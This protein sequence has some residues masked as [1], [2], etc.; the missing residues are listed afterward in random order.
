MKKTILSAFVLGCISLSAQQTALKE[1]QTTVE[2]EEEAKIYTQ[3]QIRSASG[4]E[5]I[6][7]TEDFANGIP[8]NWENY[9]N[10][11][12]GVSLPNGFWEYRGPNTIPDNTTGSRGGSAGAGTPLQSITA[13]NG[14]VIFDSD[15][16]DDGGV[17]GSGNGQA[18]A[19]HVGILIT[20]TIDLSGHPFVELKFNA[21]VR[22]LDSDFLMAVSTDGGLTYTDTVNLYPTL[23]AN[24]T[25]ARNAQLSVN[26]SA[27]AGNQSMVRIAFIFDGPNRGSYYWMMDDLEIRDLP[28]KEMRFVASGGAPAHDIIYDMNGAPHP[29]EGHIPLQQI[30]PLTF[31]SNI[32]NYGSQTQTNVVLEV[33]IYDTTNTL[34]T[35]LAST[36]PVPAMASGD[37]VDF[38]TFFTPAWTPNAAGDY[39][40]VYTLS[41]DTISTDA[42][43]DSFNLFVT[44]EPMNGYSAGESIG[45][46]NGV[47]SNS[48]G[49]NALG[50][51]GS[52]MLVQLNLS[53]PDM[54]ANGQIGVSGLEIGYSTLTVDGGDIQVEVYDTA[55]FSFTGGFGNSPLLSR[56]F[57]IA[58][59]SSGSTVRYDL[60]NGTGV[61]VMFDADQYFFVVYFFSN[62]NANLIRVANDASFASP[63]SNH[64]A[65]YNV[66]DSRWYSGY[67]NSRNFNHPWI[68]AI[69]ATNTVS[70][71]EDALSRLSMFPNPA[72]DMLTYELT[73]GG[74]YTL[75]LTDV[76]G[77]LIHQETLVSNGNQTH[78]LDLERF[79]KGV[80]TIKVS[81]SE[82]AFVNKLV[83]E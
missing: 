47:F 81:N 39:T 35:T 28:E 26:I 15:Y 21:S 24:T 79:A 54:S 49:T 45:L 63:L 55:G 31:D 38:S 78:T 80:Y 23:S 14:Y 43:R 13:A 69:T 46:D 57:T 25:V 56:Q 19:P 41:S 70:L 83:I 16:L 60:T 48:L 1:A 51:D 18:P 67:N 72:S 77:K 36:P 74:K 22:R 29:K 34:V 3:N 53:Q 64:A 50:T 8:G 42:P 11:Q 4:S 62:N 82:K 71:N 30:V 9:V 20:D 5:A 65:M 44:D 75:E 7:W 59:G 27:S 76:N 32:M 40:F 6:V 58:A 61:P 33:E 10:T 12:G 66:D 73:Q 37:T 17:S 2:T 68:R 52:G